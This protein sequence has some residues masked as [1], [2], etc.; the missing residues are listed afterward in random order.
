M[1]LPT[2]LFYF[3]NVLITSII[4]SLHNH[5]ELLM[6][7]NVI[8]L[9]QSIVAAYYLMSFY[10]S[11]MDFSSGLNIEDCYNVVICEA[12][13]DDLIEYRMS[14]DNAS[15]KHRNQ[16][17]GQFLFSFRQVSHKIFSVVNIYV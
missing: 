9:F 1:Y 11:F 8:H 6:L 15:C 13:N 17:K 10:H 14:C 5:I 16:L 7:K 12:V 2:W 4:T 3:F